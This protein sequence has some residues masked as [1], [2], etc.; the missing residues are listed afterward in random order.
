MGIIVALVI[1]NKQ[2]VK[3]FGLVA[4]WSS[5]LPRASKVVGSIPGRVLRFTSA[6]FRRLLRVVAGATEL[7]L[8]AMLSALRK[9]TEPYGI[10]SRCNEVDLSTF[11]RLLR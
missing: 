4:K 7:V 6:F 2:R 11:K 5:R 1:I 9:E 8:C 3:W 10:K